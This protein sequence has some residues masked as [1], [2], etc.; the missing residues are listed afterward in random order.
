MMNS[1]EQSKKTSSTDVQTGPDTISESSR[2]QWLDK[3]WFCLFD[4]N[5]GGIMSP[6]QIRRERR[7]RE[8][9]RQIE[10]AAILEAEGELNG[11]HQGLK[12]LDEYGN[13]VDTPPVDTVATH[14]IIENTAIEQHLDIGLDTPAAM[15]RSVIKEVSVRDLERSLNLRKIAIQAESE[16]LACP[17]RAIS[18]VPINAEWMIRWRESAEHVINP[19]L[20]ALWARALVL[21]VAAPGSFTLGLMSTLLQ[22]NKED[23]EVIRI[24]AKYAFADFIFDA[25][26]S[27]F[28]TDVHQSMFDVLEDLGLLIANPARKVIKSTDRSQFLALLTCRHKGLKLTHRDANKDLLLSVFKLSR[29]GRQ[30]FSLCDSEADLAYLLTFARQLQADGYA[31]TLGDL[32]F[33][34]NRTDFVARMTL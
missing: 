33:K 23:W 8:T 24:A 10:M 32:E 28:N 5:S 12:M 6:G 17:L 25:T 2:E 13:L 9:V 34:G 19:E 22:L 11:I 29:I 16:I 21:E 31:V 3:L 18:N 20:Q 27:Y 26:D 7:N 1:V 14:R 15:I 30:I 4:G